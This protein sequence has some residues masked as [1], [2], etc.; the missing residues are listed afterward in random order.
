[1]GSEYSK[2]IPREDDDAPSEADALAPYA[3]IDSRIPDSNKGALTADPHAGH[4][5][6]PTPL[7]A[8]KGSVPGYDAPA[9]NPPFVS[10]TRAYVCNVCTCGIWAPHAILP[11]MCNCGHPN[12][13]H[14]P[15]EEVARKGTSRDITWKKDA[16]P[17]EPRSNRKWL[18]DNA[19]A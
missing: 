12:A 7:R 1:M 5:K 8:G 16:R 6:R 14:R 10:G 3:R 13:A 4:P 15:R 18:R 17:G 19:G 2:R 11:Q 9:P